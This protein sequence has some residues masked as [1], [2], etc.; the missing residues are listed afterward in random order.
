MKKPQES[1]IVICGIVRNAEKGLRRN[2]PVIVKVLSSFKDY[3]VLIYENDSVDG[4]KEL[5]T[6]WALTHKD[7]V[8]ISIN[9]TD[10]S[11]TIPSA[12]SVEGV[13][14]F[15]SRKRIDK[16]ANLRNHYMDMLAEHVDKDDSFVPDYMMVVDLDVA[17]LYYD[18]IMS[19]FESA[20]DWDAVCAFGYSTSPYL[21]RRY[22]DTYALT[23]WGDQDNPQTEEK[24]RRNA[25]KY[26]K[27][28]PTDDWVRLAS[29]FG[30]VAIYRYEA[31]KGL[32]YVVPSLPN[33]DKRVEVKCEHFSLYKQMIECGYDKIYLNPTMVLKYQDLTFNIIWNSLKRMVGIA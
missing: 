7:K 29:G 21:R 1:N 31:V 15:F 16:M 3:R 18:S 22:H 10:P 30:G 14:P 4:T 26:G 8:V 23:E 11:H 32:R 19:S 6:N 25:D 5:L 24:V 9:Q 33:D 27:L 17:Q 13:N 20:Y 12:K 28:K 2:I